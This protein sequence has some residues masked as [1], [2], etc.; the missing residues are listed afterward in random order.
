M[1]L[2]IS[3]EFAYDELYKLEFLNNLLPYNIWA[4][5]VSYG[6][7]LLITDISGYQYVLSKCNRENYNFLNLTSHV[8]RRWFQLILTTLSLIMNYHSF[9]L[10]PPR[11]S[12]P[13]SFPSNFTVVCVSLSFVFQCNVWVVAGDYRRFEKW[14]REVIS[15]ANN[16]AH[17]L[18]CT[19]FLKLVRQFLSEEQQLLGE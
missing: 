17:Y 9:S 6:S 8:G 1:L 7:N 14:W 13:P 18:P 3:K 2:D 12:L 5:R 19:I 11:P 16:V 4:I 15:I 10:P